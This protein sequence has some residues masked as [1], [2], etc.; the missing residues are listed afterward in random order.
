MATTSASSSFGG[1]VN[2]H[3]DYI[4]KRWVEDGKCCCLKV[5]GKPCD[6]KC[7]LVEGKGVMCKKH[8]QLGHMQA[9]LQG[10]ALAR[11]DRDA[12]VISAGNKFMEECAK[13]NGAKVDSSALPPRPSMPSGAPPTARHAPPQREERVHVSDRSPDRYYGRSRSPAGRHQYREVFVPYFD[14]HDYRSNPRYVRVEEPVVVSDDD[15]SDS[16]DEQSEEENGYDDDLARGM[17]DL[18]LNGPAPR[19]AQSSEPSVRVSV[20]KPASIARATVSVESEGVPQ[21]AVRVHSERSSDRVRPLVQSAE[22]PHP[23]PRRRRRN[24]RNGA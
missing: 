18:R 23:A 8:A 24:A 1:E 4:V 22:P 10:K 17:E 15:A 2:W 7:N 9:Y 5:N 12:E 11:Q 19:I 21:H 6:Y 13:K 20:D 14:R 16:N 3:W